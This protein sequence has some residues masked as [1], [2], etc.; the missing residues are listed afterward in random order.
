MQPGAG[1]ALYQQAAAALEQSQ[2]GTGY[3]IKTVR[4]FTGPIPGGGVGAI[5]YLDV[6]D[7]RLSARVLLV[8]GP[9]P[10]EAAVA[11]TGT[12]GWKRGDWTGFR[13]DQAAAPH[14]PL[15]G[16]W[17]GPEFDPIGATPP[18]LAASVAGC[19]DGT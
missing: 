5:Y 9:G 11:R 15:P 17:S 19:L 13:G 8:S 6:R 3:T 18:L 12:T 10:A 7:T 2:G 1:T 16:R 14:L 4:Y